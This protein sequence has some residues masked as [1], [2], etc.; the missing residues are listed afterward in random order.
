MQVS[1]SEPDC[2]SG[3]VIGSCQRLC[4]AGIENRGSGV[5][6]CNC[7]SPHS[8]SVGVSSRVKFLAG[9]ALKVKIT[10]EKWFSQHVR[11]SFGY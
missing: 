7:G 2:A 3:A 6:R 11:A 4:W 8:V 10:Y 9:N 1:S 5:T